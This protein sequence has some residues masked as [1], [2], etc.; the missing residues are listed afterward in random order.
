MAFPKRLLTE[1]EEVVVELRPHWIFLGQPLLFTVLAGVTTL[2]I[3]VAFPSAPAWVLYLLGAILAV[4][5]LGL[6]ARMVRRQCTMVVLTSLRLVHRTGVLSRRTLEVRLQRVQELSCHQTL[7]G[8][9][10]RYG[11]VTVETA[12]DTGAGAIVLSQVRRP[13]AVQAL[14][15]EQLAAAQH[16]WD[17]PDEG[18]GRRSAPGSADAGVLARPTP[19]AGTP[20]PS[21]GRPPTA[22][23]RLVELQDLWR[24]GLVTDEEFAAKRAALLDQL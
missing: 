6:A 9:V 13:A 11:D 16:V 23:E 15:T 4:S 1:G 19:P 2:A 22:G 5:A 3:V 20:M 7:V 10:L 18:P 12:G 14:V 21:S 24:R 17:R 8:R